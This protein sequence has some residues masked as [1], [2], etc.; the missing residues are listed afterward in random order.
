MRILIVSGYYPPNIV[1]GG[2]ISTLILSEGLA[3]EGADVCVLTCAESEQR[4]RINGVTIDHIRSPNIYW[5]YGSARSAFKKA[6]WHA[7]ENY[8]P[9]SQR[10]VERKVADFKADIVVT[11]T[12]ENFGASAWTA[13][14]N[15]NVPVVHILRS[16]YLQCWRGSCFKNGQNCAD[17]CRSCRML[18]VGK[19]F[20]S[21]Y[22]S[23]VVGIS[24]HVLRAHDQR[25]YFENAQRVKIF[26]PIEHIADTPRRGLKSD[27]ATFGYLG[28]LQSS[29]G[30]E[31]VVRVFSSGVVSGHL[32]VA[33]KGDQDYV[34]GLHR[35]ADS[36]HVQFLGWTT[37]AE[38][39]EK[40]D[41]VIFPSLWQEP[42]GRGIA[43]AM[44]YGIPVIGARSG[45]ILELIDHNNGVL[46]D[47]NSA[48]ELAQAIQSISPANY[49]TLSANALKS[50]KRFAR[51]HI[52]QAYLRFLDKVIQAHGNRPPRLSIKAMDAERRDIRPTGA[53]SP[54]RAIAG[55]I[56]MIAGNYP[57]HITGGGEIST[58]I[59]AEGFAERGAEVRV[60]T[61]GHTCEQRTDGRVVV[62][63][64]LSPNLYWRFGSKRGR[65]QKAAWHALD[66]YNPRT[67]ALTKAKI[68]EFKPDL[69]VTS[70]LE[71]FGAT[72]WLAGHA[73]GVPVFDI[74][75]SYY[76][77]CL[78]GS[79][80]RNGTNCVGRCAVCKT[81]TVGKRHLSRYVDGVIGVSQ[82]VLN[83]HLSEGYFQNALSTV[84]YNPVVDGVFRN[85]SSRGMRRPVLGYLGKLLPTKGIEGVIEAFSSGAPIGTLLIAGNGDQNYEQELRRIADPRFVEFLGWI[86]PDALFAR[87]D[88]LVFPSIWN[89]PFG[90]GIA[91]AMRR[92][93]PV[94]AARSG[95]IPELIDD[96]ID[97]FLYDPRVLGAF[98]QAYAR[99]TN[100]DYARLSAAASAKSEIFAKDPIIGHFLSFFDQVRGITKP[101]R[102]AA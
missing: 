40:V 87:I 80:F 73:A 27:Y 43:E 77:E 64:V 55:R 49:Q 71:N 20:A 63:Q 22:V 13:A 51:D 15:R 37:P 32:F 101:S 74:I 78:W 7:V 4:S 26:N 23:G 10:V 68:D 45:G 17:Q 99:A 11:S 29:K 5:R 58:R 14:Y 89:E 92:G 82:F 12:L 75:H 102:A 46:F 59:L 100:G 65:L 66:N 86:E 44:G 84:I 52:A 97:G 83:S 93:I 96:G 16:Y 3:A 88:L 91:E 28:M 25:N 56:L 19:R 2:D 36:N 34:A 95:G 79:C 30:I 31:N 94:I 50:A 53:A 67:F 21:R 70:I 72:A 42:F 61:C 60:L 38:L 90:R 62:D 6:V 81:A 35:I 69:I 85:R 54:R 8:N 18:S 47:P 57:P 24:E 1:G 48:A 39:F 98:E 76:L 33:G 41:C 9:R